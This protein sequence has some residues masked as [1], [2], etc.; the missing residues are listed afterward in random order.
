MSDAAWAELD[1]EAG[2]ILKRL[3]TGRKVVDV[4][5]PHGWEYGAVNVGRLK[6]AK[7]KAGAVGWGVRDVLPLVELRAPFKLAQM[8][9]DSITRGAADPELKPLQDVVAQAG[10]FEDAAVFGGFDAG[11]IGG[12]VAWASNKLVPL[13][14]EPAEYPK[15]VALAVKA[16]TLAGVGAPYAL[17]LEPDAY[18]ALMQTAKQGYPPQRIIRD[19]LG[20][21]ILISAA[22][23]G[24]VVLSRRGGDFELTVGQDFSLGYASHDR[25]EVEFFVTESFAF[26]VLTPEAAVALTK[27]SRGA[28]RRR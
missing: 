3:L 15:A 24:G 17:V 21:D 10:Q 4:H 22:V 8:E 16:L 26:R 6:T 28:S 11:G 2:R 5:G 14:S 7:K 19:L 1:A 20:G 25:A 18:F 12:I 13:P 27:Q 23:T 9:L